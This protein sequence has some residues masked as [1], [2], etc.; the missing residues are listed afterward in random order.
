[1]AVFWPGNFYL[2]NY[3]VSCCNNCF[4]RKSTPQN[5]Y[6]V[7]PR[8]CQSKFRPNREAGPHRFTPCTTRRLVV[9][10]KKVQMLVPLAG[11]QCEWPLCAH[12]KRWGK[13]M[14]K[15]GQRPSRQQHHHTQTTF[16]E[17]SKRQGSCKVGRGHH[18]KT[19]ETDQYFHCT[20]PP[21]HG[22]TKLLG[23]LGEMKILASLTPKWCPGFWVL[24][25][26]TAVVQLQISLN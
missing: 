15:L 19:S 2:E 8:L 7:S 17:I 18:H 14:V 1:M 5:G 20:Q 13:T 12:Q 21:P 22:T 3:D 10:L 24:Y 9:P 26:I 11:L 16:I 4:K 25:F 23:W 6:Q